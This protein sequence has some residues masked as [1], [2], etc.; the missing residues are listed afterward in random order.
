M[1]KISCNSYTG[2][3]DVV[4]KLQRLIQ[5]QYEELFIAVL[6]HGSVATDEINAYS[7]FDGLLIVKDPYKESI[8]LRKF[9]NQSLKIIYRFDPLQHH[10]WFIIFQSQL[11]NYP[12][13][14]FPI[15]LFEFS[16][17]IYP[18]Y[19]IKLKIYL[20]EIVDYKESFRSITASI[21]KTLK[22]RHKIT[23][24][25]QLKVFLSELMLLPTLYYQAMNKKC[26]FKKY[27]FDFVKSEIS[28]EAWKAI[29]ISSNIRDTWRYKFSYPKCLFIKSKDFS[30]TKKLARKYLCPRIPDDINNLLDEKFYKA[31]QMLISEMDYKVNEI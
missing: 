26:I 3:L 14:Y 20:P 2:N 15:E 5:K 1:I 11:F 10:G 13:T 30:L 12:Q 27:S 6:V 17:T 4:L 22:N 21:T 19:D 29:E 9:L 8:L 7:D 25:Y 18:D 24:M 31:C 16:K 23:G 28:S